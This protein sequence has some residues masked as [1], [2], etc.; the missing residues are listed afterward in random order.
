MKN[1]AA[2]LGLITAILICLGIFAKTNHYTGGS[3]ALV[4][5][6]GI[7][8][9]V[10]LMINIVNLVKDNKYNLSIV[11]LGIFFIIYT[12]G[13][14]FVI[15]HW[16]FGLSIFSFGY[17]LLLISLFIIYFID[18]K[19]GIDDKRLPMVF[20]I[21]SIVSVS[22]IYIA[23]FRGIS[24]S[25]L[26]GFVLANENETSTK[27][28]LMQQNENSISKLDSKFKNIKEIQE[29]HKNTI[30]LINEIEALKKKLAQISSDNEEI[31]DYRQIKYM[32]NYDVPN[33]ILIA[34]GKGRQIKK[35]LDNFRMNLIGLNLGDS[36]R[37]IVCKQLNTSDPKAVEGER[38]TWESM[39]FEYMPVISAIA[40]LTGI[41]VKVLTSEF[42][43]LHHMIK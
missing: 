7:L 37:L 23:S 8:F 20:I 43:V 40:T 15:Q 5:S 38:Q 17:V 26:D 16:S 12:I 30:L 32:G 22:L 41:Q 14:L 21:L 4:L 34:S 25:I 29:I 35:S 27:E 31:N 9:P 6:I 33:E 2:T 39:N 10:Y 1:K 36:L 24:R 13:L 42:V 18:S 19:K 11:F 28:I 3:I